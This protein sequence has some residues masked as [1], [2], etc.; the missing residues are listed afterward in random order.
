MFIDLLTYHIDY[1][2]QNEDQVLDEAEIDRGS[3]VYLR[4]QAPRTTSTAS[5]STAATASTPLN[6]P[7]YGQEFVMISNL[8]YMELGSQPLITLQP[9][10]QPTPSPHPPARG[11]D[12]TLPIPGSTI[13]QS[14]S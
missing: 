4:T 7:P 2:W 14:P 13:S 6:R 8:R 10:P 1:L 12:R 11:E 3:M 5:T 9:T